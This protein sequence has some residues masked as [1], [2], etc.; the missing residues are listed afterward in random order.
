MGMTKKKFD[1]MKFAA[2]DVA[3]EVWDKRNHDMN[4]K[5]RKELA[6]N[7]I[8]AAGKVMIDMGATPE[9][10]DTMK[11]KAYKGFIEDYEYVGGV[12]LTMS[13]ASN[14]VMTIAEMAPD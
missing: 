2:R 7:A 13:P 12:S 6:S 4:D 3:K 1:K 5:E 8:E 10:V 11:D 9:M 14:V